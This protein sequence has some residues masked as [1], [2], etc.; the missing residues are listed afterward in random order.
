MWPAIRVAGC[1]WIDGGWRNFARGRLLLTAV[2]QVY[3]VVVHTKAMLIILVAAAAMLIIILDIN[4]RARWQLRRQQ[5]PLSPFENS[6]G[7]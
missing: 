4:K 6:N 7:C 5:I 3:S 2:I 1:G